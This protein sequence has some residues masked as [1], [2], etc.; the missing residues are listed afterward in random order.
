[1]VVT[2]EFCFFTKSN[3]N[4]NQ[5]S[6]FAKIFSLDFAQKTI[7]NTNKPSEIPLVTF[8][9]LHVIL[10]ILIFICPK[11]FSASLSSTNFHI[12]FL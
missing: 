3:L 1:M 2:V 9:R 12:N 6:N 11:R 4:K 10:I 7:K 5:C 8:V